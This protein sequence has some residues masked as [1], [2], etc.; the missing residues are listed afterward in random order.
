MTLNN[1]LHITKLKRPRADKAELGRLL[2]AAQRT[3]EDA[4][5][6]ELSADTRLD[7]AYRAIMQVG[8]VAV[9][10]SGGRP[11]GSEA[12]QHRLVVQ[13]L[14]KT[15]G[16]SAEQIQ[17]LDSYRDARDQRDDRGVPI[18]AEVADDC[19]TDAHDLLGDMAKWL[20]V[21][22]PDLD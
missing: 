15:A 5:I 1:L 7:L 12:G 8:R 9:L 13:A 21:H 2:G 19:L 10:A 18:S 17:V 4:C 6:A 16:I 20:I 14:A 22:R 11:T 3:L